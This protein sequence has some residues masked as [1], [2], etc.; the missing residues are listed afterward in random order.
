MLSAFSY[1]QILTQDLLFTKEEILNGVPL[2]SVSESIRLAS[3]LT[4]AGLNEREKAI[5]DANHQIEFISA[6]KMTRKPEE[7]ESAMVLEDQVHDSMRGRVTEMARLTKFLAKTKDAPTLSDRT[8]NI[9]YK[10]GRDVYIKYVNALKV[11][12]TFSM[13]NTDNDMLS[14]CKVIAKRCKI[15]METILAE[16]EELW[17]PVSPPASELKKLKRSPEPLDLEK[18]AKVARSTARVLSNVSPRSGDDG[19]VLGDTFDS[20]PETVE[21]TTEKT[22]ERQNARCMSYV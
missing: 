1:K 10:I 4:S 15:D 22:L 18:P 2:V 12:N 3:S 7:G 9:V 17:R 13:R 8:K 19:P 5:K 16:E 11:E 6:L 14:E 21:T 20:V